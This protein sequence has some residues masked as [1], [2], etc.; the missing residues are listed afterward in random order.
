MSVEAART[1][2]TP[3]RGAP[4]RRSAWRLSLDA[5]TGSEHTIP[6]A[7]VALCVLVV[8]GPL[9]LHVVTV[10]PLQL[11]AGLQT[12]A[13]HQRLPG[14]PIDD[15]NA[16]F[17]T[18]ALG[19]AAAHAWL[20]GHI[21]WWNPYEGIG[22]PLA[23]EMQSAAFFP[24]VLL[25]AGSWGFVPY[26]MLLE[27]TAGLST[28]FL[29]RRLGTGRLPATAGGV[30]F[31]LCGTFALFWH[32]TANPVALLP[33]ALLGVEHAFDA[34]RSRRLGGWALLGL[35]LALSITAGFPEVAYIDGLLVVLWAAARLVAASG[36]RRGFVARVAGGGLLG[37]LLGAPVL[38]A[39]LTYLPH[40]SVGGHNGAFANGFLVSQALPQLIL[41]YAYGP[42][43]G[44]S[45]TQVPDILGLIWG[46][47]GGF[48]TAA[49]VMGALV[50]LV[51]RRLRLLRLCLAAWIFVGLGKTYGLEPIVH[52]VARFPGFHS[53][54]AYRY[55]APSWEMAVVVLAA[56]GID[57]MARRRV[58]LAM[59]AGAAVVTSG[60]VVWAALSA[61]P[62][63]DVRHDTAHRHAYVL[64]SCI[65]ALVAVAAVAIG[66]VLAASGR[67][68]ARQL[69]R[70][71]AAGAIG[72]DA[73]LMAAV[74]MLSA[75][76]R[77][78]V[79]F[80][81]VKFL[82][83]NL[84]SQRFAT[85]G[86]IQPNF[87]SYFGIAE[88]NVNDVP[89]PSAYARYVTGH[90]DHNVDPLVFSGTVRLD[91][92]GSSP[93]QELSANLAG[94]EAAGVKFVVEPGS[95]MDAAGVA[96]P[97]PSLASQ[98][99]LVYQD[100][101]AQVY[102]LPKP[103]PLFSTPGAACQVTASSQ[104]SARVT[105]ARAATLV[106]RELAMPGWTA[107][108]GGMQHAVHSADSIFQSTSVPAGTSEV[109]FS[110][111]PPH[112]SWALVAFFVGLAA[113]V[114]RVTGGSV[115]RRRPR[116]SPWGL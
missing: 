11:F 34:A 68:T 108:V 107:D 6:V 57:D 40:A 66:G 76:K 35:A 2:P 3:P 113:L 96:F 42:I 73:A 15:P 72:L 30:A 4:R 83:A 71:L 47:V 8:N 54:A 59:V 102:Q 24:P 10:N 43:F 94:Y 12:V 13:A 32:S 28:Y 106:W 110:F 91:P 111:S 103:L 26:H 56:L 63:L 46:N 58:P 92:A 1:R 75:P 101:S 53:I 86:P 84:G 25:M 67:P 112:S 78:P 33:M 18:Q 104:T 65:W 7:V 21:P 88:I 39:F 41:P 17:V 105:C 9:L 74:P 37:G 116:P 5:I 81:V 44:F 49:L 89:V 50:G 87:G 14:Y 85:L 22:A 99:T 45:T 64:A 114:F 48:V 38:V 100:A 62:V 95:G 55:S 79:D 70:V 23:G 29:L 19:H 80:A 31:G 90:L 16:G 82:Q 109:I 98:V 27:V 52:W 51:G 69:S 115:A 36:F 60:L 93:A 77:A 20:H 97:P 61:W